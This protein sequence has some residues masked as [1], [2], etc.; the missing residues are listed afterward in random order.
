[1]QINGETG[2]MLLRG[3]A[4]PFAGIVESAPIA[5][6]RGRLETAYA[7]EREVARSGLSGLP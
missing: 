6:A 5:E 4:Y 3:R 1:M 2:G 7:R